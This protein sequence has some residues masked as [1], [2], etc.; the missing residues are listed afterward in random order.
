MLS[1]NYLLT[2]QHGGKLEPTVVVY[3]VCHVHLSL[4]AIIIVGMMFCSPLL[5]FSFVYGSM[6]HRQHY[7]QKECIAV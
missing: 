3:R 4:Y 7:R 6:V 5:V 1:T 2:G